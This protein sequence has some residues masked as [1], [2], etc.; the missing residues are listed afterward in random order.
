MSKK[1]SRSATASKAPEATAQIVAPEAP[2]PET[3]TDRKVRVFWHKACLNS[4][5]ST[6]T[7]LKAD[8]TLK[9]TDA[10][11]SVPN[12]ENAEDLI[13]KDVYS[14]KRGKRIYYL[15]DVTTA[16]IE[17]ASAAAAAKAAAAAEA[18]AEATK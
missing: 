18:T 10:K 16:D 6:L 2:Q 14:L 7:L 17:K 5:E 8:E 4:K 15:H 3:A 12:P 11:V 13:I 9:K 1:N